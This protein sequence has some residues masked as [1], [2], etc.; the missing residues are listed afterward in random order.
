MYFAVNQIEK[1]NGL[2]RESLENAL[3]KLYT[4][5]KNSKRNVALESDA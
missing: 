2:K 1:E 3:S 4:L 5:F